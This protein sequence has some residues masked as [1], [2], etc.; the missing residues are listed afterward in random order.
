MKFI[1]VFGLLGL[2]LL[3][4]CSKDTISRDEV[5]GQWSLLPD[6]RAFLPT[7]LNGVDV[8]LIIRGDSSFSVANMPGDVIYGGIRADSIMF[9]GDGNWKVGKIEGEQSILFEMNAISPQDH[10][11][12]NAKFS[13]RVVR[14]K[15][16]LR[17]GRQYSDPDSPYLIEFEKVE[18]SK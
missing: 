18:L 15:S 9:S 8:T 17:L 10:S 13:F 3:Q 7:I 5:V 11:K 6:S 16:G 1:L 12:Q 2:S 14:E 4:G